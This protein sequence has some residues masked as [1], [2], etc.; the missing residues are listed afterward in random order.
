MARKWVNDEMDAVQLLSKISS[1]PDLEPFSMD[2]LQVL[3]NNNCLLF[4]LYIWIYLQ[5]GFYILAIG[6]MASLLSMAIECLK[7]SYKKKE[8]K[9]KANGGGCQITIRLAT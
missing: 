6:L 3:L 2:Q 7:G 8:D 1:R 4:L 5:G 9:R